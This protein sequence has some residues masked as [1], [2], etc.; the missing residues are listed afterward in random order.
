M[1]KRYW[2][3]GGIIGLFLSLIFWVV[4]SFSFYFIEKHS[5]DS[6]EFL[7]AVCLIIFWSGVLFICGAFIGWLYGKIKIKNRFIPKS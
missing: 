3:R 2:L 4:A 1:Q 7:V 6:L 5:L